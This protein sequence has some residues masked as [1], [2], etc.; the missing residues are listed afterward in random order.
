MRFTSGVAA[1]VT[2]LTC[3]TQ[4]AAAST[5][6]VLTF[7]PET[8]NN[9]HKIAL[10][11]LSPSTA[12]VVLA[13]RAGL[14][15]YHTTHGLTNEEIDAVNT[16][17]L[18]TKLFHNNARRRAFIL[19]P[20]HVEAE[21]SPQ[22]RMYSRFSISNS[23]SYAD[24]TELFSDFTE[25]AES[26]PAQTEEY[27]HDE[28]TAKSIVADKPW[29]HI[30]RD[31]GSMMDLARKLAKDKITVTA[32]LVPEEQSK[33]SWGSYKSSRRAE[34][35]SKRQITHKLQ[36]EEPMFPS[37]SSSEL[38]ILANSSN[39]TTNATNTPLPGILP[40][41]YSSKRACVSRTRDCTGHGSCV[42][43]YTDQSKK[44]NTTTAECWGCACGTTT[45]NKLTT[46]WAGPACQ[47]KDI[48]V[49][50]WLIALFTI[51][52]LSLVGFAVGTI[53]S[54]GEEQLPSVIGAGVSG[55][56]ARK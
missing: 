8:A 4:L 9:K 43:K 25:Q 28:T 20:L 1:V 41:C 38:H 29:F 36:D 40:A 10:S 44:Q 35:L 53:W 33:S 31:A 37:S 26:D 17:G 13:Q 5:A 52:L 18:R 2:L 30:T 3:S 56:T 22:L 6:Y 27:I 14:E 12:R 49:E 32:V 39:S 34:F 55:P 23:P 24:T 51:G 54:M 15:D 21:L 16:Y 50:F 19:A 45:S 7:E 11:G 42:L 47:K 48:S 46:H